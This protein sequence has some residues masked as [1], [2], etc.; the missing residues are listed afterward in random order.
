MV[1]YIV[2]GLG[3]AGTSFCETL[4][5]NNKTFVVFNDRSQT[6][7]RV[8][9]G[10]Y[11]PIILKRFTLSWKADE[12]LFYATEFYTQ[13]EQFLGVH[14]NRRL[15]V[16]R[17]F[18]SIEEQNLWYEAA[19][20]ERLK[21]FLDTQLVTNNNP[22]LNVPNKLGKVLHTGKLNTSLLLDT[23]EQWLV[24]QGIMHYG[25]LDYNKLKFGSKDVVYGAITARHI[26]F[27]EG[28][29]LTTNPYFKYLPLQGSKGEYLIIESKEL[30][31]ESLVKF[32]LFLIPL[33]NDRYKVGA[34]YNRGDK[35]N[36]ITLWAEKEIIN[37]LNTL[38]KCKYTVVGQEAGVRPTVKDRRPLVG[39]H[40]QYPN[41]WVLNGFGSHGIIIGP[42]ASKALFEHIEMQRPL[43]KEMDIN[44]FL[45][46]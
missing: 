16:L 9:G 20:K 2:V 27:C 31:E 35:D 19:D 8:A 42:W 28:F 25:T 4:R 5:R 24:E 46:N 34:T 3:L 10:L 36:D 29:G 11:N 41:M 33:G 23:Y 32:S 38:L 39:K 45:P 7:S 6:S 15:S 37:K 43:D 26:I 17:K 30:K 13:L 1:D 12:Q 14:F 22:H 44:R 18:A 21:L 40:P